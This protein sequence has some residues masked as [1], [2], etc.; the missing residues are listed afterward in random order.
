MT[1][2]RIR[3]TAFTICLLESDAVLGP[4]PALPND[5][6]RRADLARRGC[7]EVSSSFMGS[8]ELC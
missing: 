1:T 8:A 3:T 7:D 4:P 2:A 6:T 5:S